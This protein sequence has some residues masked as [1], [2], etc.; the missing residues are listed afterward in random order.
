V[1]L[2]QCVLRRGRVNA[3]K[4]IA[5]GSLAGKQGKKLKKVVSIKEAL[6]IINIK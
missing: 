4:H 3:S 2:R 1:I 6:K 5:S